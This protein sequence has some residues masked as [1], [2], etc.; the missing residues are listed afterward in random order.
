MNEIWKDILGYEG[1]YQ[2]SNLGRVRSLD[3]TVK[4]ENGLSKF[5]KGK[6]I[7][8]QLSKWGYCQCPLNN[9]GMKLKSVH[10]LVYEAFNGPIPKGM[11]INH[12]NEIK[13]DNRLENLSL[14]DCKTNINYGTG[15]ERR[16]KK[17]INGKGSKEV[18][19]Y[20]KDGQFFAKYPSLREV[21][22]VNGY[23]KQNISIACKN[24]LVR[25]GFRWRYA[26]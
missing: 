10:R 15:I 12:I 18:L 17:R 25:Y 3:R 7:K 26:S 4:Y 20:T 16:A 6:L 9:K 13:T 5:R 22:R 23:K 8:Q 24:N 11:Q 21:E 14:M 2:V 19:Q 1:L